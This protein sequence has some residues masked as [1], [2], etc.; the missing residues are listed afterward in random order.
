VCCEQVTIKASEDH[1]N[2]APSA[3]VPLLISDLP[4]YLWWRAVPKL[5]D[6]ELYSR[7]R[8]ISDRVVIDSARFNDPE[9][10]MHRLAKTFD[11]G[12]QGAA[13]SDLNWAR[14]TT[15][16]ALLAGF[17]DVQAYRPRLD[18]LQRITVSYAAPADN[19]S[20]ISTRAL[21]LGGWL[22]SRL[23]WKFDPAASL[24]DG[25][26]AAFGFKAGDRSVQ[27]GFSHTERPIQP[28]HLAS[29]TLSTDGEGCCE[30]SVRRSADG[31]RI[32]TAATVEDE[33]R[34]KRVLSYETLE[35][36]ALISK[37]LEIPGFDRVYEEAVRAAAQ[38]IGA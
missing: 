37:E 11:H 1:L 30:F 33:Q 35:E 22:V 20:A 9:G 38:L 15:W 10:D 4:V 28:G 13:L 18:R 29:V 27:L 25:N 7:L 8:A 2:E 26:S 31:A 34:P 21:L 23:G 36:S 5:Q 24:R 16:R 6:K 14:L 12:G 19:P 32:E 17:Y 3:I